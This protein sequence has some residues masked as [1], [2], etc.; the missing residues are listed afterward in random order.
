[1]TTTAAA[2]EPKALVEREDALDG[3]R[4]AA[5]VLVMVAHLYRFEPSNAFLHWL[6]R[7]F[8]SGWM[9]V[10]LF[11]ALSGFLITRLLLAERDSPTRYRDFYMRRA[12]RIMP[13]Y[14]AYLLLVFL[15]LRPDLAKDWALTFALFAQNLVLVGNDGVGPWR[16]LD[17]L[18]SISVEEQFYLLWPLLLYRIPQQHLRWFCL[19][20]IALA[21][22]LKLLLLRG[23]WP[24]AFYVIPA[25]RMDVLAAGALAAVLW[26][27]LAPNALFWKLLG[28][29]LLGMFLLL[30][31]LF[32]ELEGF[33][34]HKPGV[35]AA[36]SVLLAPALAGLVLAASQARRFPLLCR[37]LRVKPLFFLGRYSYGIYL[38]HLAWAE[39]VHAPLHRA[40]L[41]YLPVNATVLL[42][43]SAILL[44]AIGSSL[45]SYHLI[46]EPAL[47][48]KRLFTPARRPP[49]WQAPETQAGRASAT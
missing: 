37:V 16:G 23:D 39:A 35:M 30:I 34:M 49:E 14:Y 38:T 9:G 47:R 13:A 44:L 36:I 19:T 7:L 27:Q 40:L 4:G 3:L 46:E 6:N 43:G 17:H 8:G 15:L 18:W 25:S 29:S 12:L 11:F 20:V 45:L 24:L 10:D 1:M 21:W 42:S 2:T 33:G 41:Q 22:P 28:P 32:F 5:L 31:V 48:L 26:G